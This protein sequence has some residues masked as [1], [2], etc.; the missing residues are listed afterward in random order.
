MSQGGLPDDLSPAVCGWCGDPAVTEVV[1]RPG[2]SKKQ[3]A[4]VCE[5]HAKDFEARGIKTTRVEFEEKRERDR[6]RSAWLSN[7][8]WR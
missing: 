5:A 7:R 4:P 6:K 8:A 3:T 2:R 1:T